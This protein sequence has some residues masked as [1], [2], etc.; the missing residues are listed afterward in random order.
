MLIHKKK[1]N[2]QKKIMTKKQLAEIIKYS[3][4]T[5]IYIITEDN[6]LQLIFCPFE[7]IVLQNVGL[8]IQGQIMEVKGVKITSEVITVFN[9]EDD[10]YYYY[11]FDIMI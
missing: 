10:Y 4:P 7:V 9:I 6:H 11:H 2:V 1:Y 5:E 3:F 8:L